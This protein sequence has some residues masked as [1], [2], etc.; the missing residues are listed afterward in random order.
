MCFLAH[1]HDSFKDDEEKKAIFSQYIKI[2]YLIETESPNFEESAELYNFIL[3]DV[4]PEEEYDDRII[5]IDWSRMI[6]W[7]INYEFEIDFYT[8]INKKKTK[9]KN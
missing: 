9:I 5:H 4:L 7:L 3:K 6:G 2:A 8:F 1:F